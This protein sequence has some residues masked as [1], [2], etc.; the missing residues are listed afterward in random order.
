MKSIGR[1]IGFT[2]AAMINAAVCFGIF[3][4]G[5]HIAPA[6]WKGGQRNER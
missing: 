3:Y 6:S 4:G 1:I 5:N 2:I